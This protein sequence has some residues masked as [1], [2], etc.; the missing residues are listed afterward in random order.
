MASA[1]A[2]LLHAWR[3]RQPVQ[4]DTNGGWHKCSREKC[5]IVQLKE[6]VCVQG[7]HVVS[8]PRCSEHGDSNCVLVNDLYVCKQV[9]VFHVCDQRT[10]QTISGRCIISGL[11]CLEQVAVQCGVPVSNKRSRRRNNNVH[12]CRQA[13]NI[14]VYELLFSN[15]RIL[16][17]YNKTAAALD[18]A[19]RKA[20]RIIK[21]HMADQNQVPYQQLVDVFTAARLRL[22]S[23]EHFIKCKNMTDKQ[24]ICEYYSC[25]GTRIWDL[26]LNFLPTRSM[27]EP[28]MAALL[29]GMRRGVACD[30]MHAIPFDKFLASALPDAHSIKDA[31]ISRRAFTQAKNSLYLAV[32]AFVGKKGNS[33]EQ[34]QAQFELPKPGCLQILTQTR[35]H[36]AN[37]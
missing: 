4:F 27:F 15:K 23:I 30:G 37:E 2:V 1:R 13:A 18:I 21:Q 14:L 8:T 10:C 36:G 24:E 7:R 22:R 32:Q 17:E 11:S 28:V 35:V 34:I 25:I 29:Y 26:L 16:N 12:T 20:Q 9:G 31:D 6:Y 3:Q 19:R 5:N 33:V